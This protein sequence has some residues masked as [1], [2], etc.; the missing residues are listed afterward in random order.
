MGIIKDFITFR[1]D[2]E[3]IRRYRQFCE[4]EVE[5]YYMCKHLEYELEQLEM[6]AGK[7]CLELDK[8]GYFDEN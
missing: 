7:L 5:Y 2:K 6:M 8:G 3:H 4:K 1:K